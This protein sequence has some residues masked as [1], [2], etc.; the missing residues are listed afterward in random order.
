M[1][2]AT[3]TCLASGNMSGKRRLSTS[4]DASNFF[5]SACA[6]PFSRTAARLLSA[7]VIVG[8]LAW[9]I[10]T[11]MKRSVRGEGYAV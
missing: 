6:A 4:A 9:Y 10:E 7:R 5:A 1:S 11:F 3:C 8:M 2:E